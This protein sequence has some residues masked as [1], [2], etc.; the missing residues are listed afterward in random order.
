MDNSTILVVDDDQSIRYLLELFLR[1]EGFSVITASNGFAAIEAVKNNKIDLILMDIMM[2]EID[3]FETSKRILAMKGAEH[4]PIILITA[5]K[6]DI[7]DVIRG[8]EDG[9]VEYLNKP[10]EKDELIARVKS[11]LRIKHLNDK[12]RELLNKVLEQQKL[13]DKEFAIARKVQIAM[14]PSPKQSV[15]GNKCIIETYYKAHEFI[16]GDMY[17]FLDYGEDRLGVIVADV[18]GHGPSSA[19]I[20]A[21]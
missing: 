17:D 13:M 2:P 1:Q 10:V 8:L 19:M 7:R 15:F 5:K 11:M 21:V 20:M 16:G 3:G 18:S 9:A 14:L 6:R 12:N 4:I